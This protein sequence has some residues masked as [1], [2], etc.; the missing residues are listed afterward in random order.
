MKYNAIIIGAGQAGPFLA[1][2]LVDQ[3]QK[4][5]LVE[6]YKIGGSCVN[7]G[8]IPTKM[9]IASARAIHMARRGADFGFETGEIKV[10]I[11]AVIDRVQGRVAEAHGGMDGWM[12]GMDNLD[13]YDAYAHFEGTENGVHRVNVNDEILE[14][15]RVILNV[16]KRAYVPDIEGLQDVDYLLNESILNLRE[17]PDHL[18]ILGGGYIGL[19]MGQ[20]WRRFGAKVTIVESHPHMLPREDSDIGQEAER[21]LK[22]E[23][24]NIK[25]GNKAIAVSQAEDG[26]VTVALEG[27][28]G[29]QSTISG[30]HLLVAI[31]RRSNADKLNLESVGVETDKRNHILVDDQLQTNIDGIYAV[32]DVNG[33]GSFTHTSYQDHEILW[34]NLQGGDRK[35]NRNMAYALYIDPPLGRVGMSEKEAR[36][37]GRNILMVKKPMEHVGRAIE[38]SETYGFFKLLVDADTEQFLGA[39]VFGYHGDDVVQIISYYMATGSSYKLMQEALPIHPTIGEF[40]PTLLGELKPLE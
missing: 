38:Q 13:V 26:T 1:A 18:V 24:I 6:G 25:C 3:G 16:G 7:Y 36:E 20:A 35:I 17:I 40:M 14:S 22:Y 4:V 30:S 31:G 5:A 9:M 10:D 15:E 33:R 11:N 27:L 19:E 2:K 29:S 28:D 23:G 12:R 8:C 32:G 21:V 34:N 39:T 37:S